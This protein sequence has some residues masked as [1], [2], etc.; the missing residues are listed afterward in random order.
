MKVLGR[1]LQDAI[2]IPVAELRARY[3]ALVARFLND[4]DP[5]SASSVSNPDQPVP[6]A[7]LL[8]VSQV[9]VRS[10]LLKPTRSAGGAREEGHSGADSLGY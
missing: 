6:S 4:V 10:T 5:T 9:F 3:P 1:P 2:F 7:H 8:S